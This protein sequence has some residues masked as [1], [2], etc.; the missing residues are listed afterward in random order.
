MQRP[1]NGQSFIDGEWVDGQAAEW[2]RRSPSDESPVWQG[3]WSTPQQALDAVK[4][5][6]RAGPV[7]AQTDLQQR[8]EICRKFGKLVEQRRD[9]RIL[10]CIPQFVALDE[11]LEYLTEECCQGSCSVDPGCG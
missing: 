2:E 11:T 5:A 3:C 8:V 6:R 7:W 9:G 10:Y 1:I 4:A